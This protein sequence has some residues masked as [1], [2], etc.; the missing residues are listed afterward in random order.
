M[1]TT[2]S[3]Q[4]FDLWLAQGAALPGSQSPG[5][6]L[7]AEH[8]VMEAVLAAMEVEAETML[9]GGSLRPEFWADV[10]DFNGNF[11]HMCHR[12]K[13]EEHL[14]P[15][16][17]RT[18]LLEARQEQAIREE[19]RSGKELTLALC[20]GVGEADWEKVMRLVSIYVHILRPHMRREETGIFALAA[21]LPEAAQQDLRRAFAAVDGQALGERGR[22]HFV[23]VARR[24]ANQNGV[25]HDLPAG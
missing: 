5:H 13:E 8:H 20:E 7:L 23:T 15:V 14:I 17:F 21:T 24:L 2:S 22:R 1:P 4:A 10:V 9:T 25:G 6:E 12:V 18:G 11:V 3:K 19:H 16:L